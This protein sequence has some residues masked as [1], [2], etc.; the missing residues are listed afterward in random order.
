M[1][2]SN[3]AVG[4]YAPDFE[5]PGVDKQVHHLG[6]Y[7]S[8]CR[9]LGVVFI[10]NQCPFVRN[11]LQRLK[12]LQSDFAE[13]DFILIAINGNQ[14]NVK[15]SETLAQ[16]KMFAEEHDFNFPYLRD[17]NQDVTTAFSA[18]VTPEVFLL[19]GQGVLFYR[20][21]IDDSPES[22]DSVKNS[23][24]R[25]AIAALLNGENLETNLT[26]PVGSP[27]K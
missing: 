4:V 16:M 22:A 12:Q 1:D 8:S 15:I 25:E 5:L 21:A 23:Y 18:T 3:L 10:N 6:R 7:L 27:L 24:L 14:A 26:T 19:D 9:A 20:G 11:Y 13:K 17:H 2:T